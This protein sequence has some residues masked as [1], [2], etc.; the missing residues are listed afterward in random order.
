ML[1]QAYVEAIYRAPEFEFNRLSQNYWWGVI[2][3]VSAT[4]KVQTI[5]DAF[6]MRAEDPTF[7]RPREVIF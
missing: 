2:S 3:N 6:P 1:R 7:T 4:M 5:L